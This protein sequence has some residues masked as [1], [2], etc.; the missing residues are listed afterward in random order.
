LSVGIK[1]IIG[2]LSFDSSQ[3]SFGECGRL[4]CQKCTQ[5]PIG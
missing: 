3:L 4:V 2:Q 5:N 1:E